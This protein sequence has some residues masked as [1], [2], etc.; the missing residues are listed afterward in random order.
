MARAVLPR[1]DWRAQWL[2]T[3]HA[4][5]DAEVTLDERASELDEEE[6]DADDAEETEEAEA[7]T[8]PQHMHID[9][10]ALDAAPDTAAGNAADACFDAGPE[11]D[12]GVV[13]GAA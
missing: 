13:D 7:G 12:M 1:R 10:T 2:L 8:E 4:G 6:G 5:A 3:G 9:G 11:E